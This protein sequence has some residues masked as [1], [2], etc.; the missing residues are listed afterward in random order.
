MAVMKQYDAEIVEMHF[1]DNHPLLFRQKTTAEKIK[2]QAVIAPRIPMDEAEEMGF[3]EEETQE[4]RQLEK[5]LRN[6]E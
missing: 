3:S 4:D 6:N 1:S 5:E 2:A